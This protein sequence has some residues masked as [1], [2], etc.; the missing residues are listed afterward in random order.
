MQILNFLKLFLLL[1]LI[2]SCSR[3]SAVNLYKE[4]M[5]AEEQKNFYV[6]IEMYEEVVDKFTT[7]EYAES[8]LVRLSVIY[9]NDMKDARKAI[10][11]YRRL[12]TLFP[13]STQAPTMIFLAAF[14]YNNELHNIDS[15][16]ILY[17]TFLQRY[18]EHELAASAKF[19]IQNLGKDPGEALR[20]QTASADES[21]SQKLK[22]AARK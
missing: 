1:I 4:G 21:K 6:A 15:A 3:K 2:A 5:A 7:S 18:P 11:S 13:N 16:K 12:Y 20:T 10:D 9:N 17:E 19:E 8:S 14:I 22:K